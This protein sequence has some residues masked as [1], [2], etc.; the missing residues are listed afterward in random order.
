MNFDS[1]DEALNSL[2]NEFQNAYALK[3]KDT[4]HYASGNLAMN[5]KHHFVFDG[6]YYRIY[7]SLE[8]YWKYLE[9][10]TKPSDVVQIC[11]RF[12]LWKNAGILDV[13]R[14]FLTQSKDKSANLNHVSDFSSL[15]TAI[16][17]NIFQKIHKLI[18]PC[19]LLC[20]NYKDY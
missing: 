6:R 7:L 18:A 3:L 8:D 5:Q 19:D 2:M 20:Y 14:V 4:N 12:L 1:I 9:N 15:P 13:F 16:I 11:D 10:G 17:C